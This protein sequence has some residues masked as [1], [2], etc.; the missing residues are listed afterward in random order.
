[1]TKIKKAAVI[2]AVAF[3]AAVGAGVFI[4]HEV[5]DMVQISVENSN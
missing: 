4:F 5:A 2:L 3:V 1:L